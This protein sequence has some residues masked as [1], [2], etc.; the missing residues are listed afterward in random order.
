MHISRTR[1]VVYISVITL[2]FASLAIIPEK[3]R[4]PEEDFQKFFEQYLTAFRQGDEA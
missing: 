1:L 4:S 3:Q 2:L